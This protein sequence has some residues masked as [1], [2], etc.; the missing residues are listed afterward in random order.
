MKNSRKIVG[1]ILGICTFVVVCSV[2]VEDHNITYLDAM[3]NSTFEYYDQV[4]FND[5]MDDDDKVVEEGMFN[6]YSLGKHHT[7]IYYTVG[8]DFYGLNVAYEVVDTTKPILMCR[9]SYTIVCGMILIMNLY[10][11]MVIILIKCQ[12]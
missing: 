1:V 8:N 9:S 2:V 11:F 4:Y 5:Y 3:Q 12:F 10:L 7:T 6:T